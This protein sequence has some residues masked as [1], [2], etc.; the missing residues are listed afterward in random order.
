MSGIDPGDD[1]TAL[2]AGFLVAGGGIGL[3]NPALAT[4]ALGVVEPRRSGMASGINSTFRQVGIA[5]GIATW[6]AIFQHVVGDEFT[7]RLGGRAAGEAADFVAFGGA[8]RQGGRLAQVADQAFVTGLDRILVL[9]AI[10]AFA[11]ALL[12]GLLVRPED[13]A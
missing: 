5:T 7:R 4:A 1:W 2:L 3:T 10:V 11:G 6:G 12:S 13:F 9:A 8:T